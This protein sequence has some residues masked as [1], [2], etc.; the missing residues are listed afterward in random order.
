MGAWYLR[1][2]LDYYDGDLE[3]AIA[4]YN[5]GP[6]NVNSWLDDP[7]VESR[8]DFLRW[9]GFGSTREY[10]ETVSLNYGV[11]QALYRGTEPD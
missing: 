8:D 5:G 6:G 1:H 2:L 9:I 3:L 10:L 4:A 7:L 11:Y